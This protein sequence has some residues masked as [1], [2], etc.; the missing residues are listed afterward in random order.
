MWLAA[1]GF[2]IAVNYDFV[3]AWINK[4]KLYF[5]FSDKLP[6]F[7]LTSGSVR[8]EA[9]QSTVSTLPGAQMMDLFRGMFSLAAGAKEEQ[10]LQLLCSTAG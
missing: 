6:A 3:H 2:F 9:K 5:K 4:S 7:Y 8:S 10:R 1:E